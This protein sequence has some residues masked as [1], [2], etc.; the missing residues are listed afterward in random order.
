MMVGS[1]AVT[2]TAGLRE[3]KKDRTRQA[4]REAALRLFAERGF[5]GVTVAEIA[6]EAD[7]S[8]ATVFNYFPTKE[9]LV[10]GGME[11]FEA[12]LVEAVREREPGESALTAFTRFIVEPRGWLG[13]KDP[14]AAKR[15]TAMTRVITTSSELLARENEIFVRYT[16]SLAELVAAETGASARDPT[17][18]V[19]AN[20]M[21]GVHRALL[22]E[23]RKEI[24]AG[25]S[26]TQVA[27]RVRAHGKRVLELLERGLRDYA[28]KRR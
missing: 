19:A 1:R 14:E 27:R 24:L 15:L 16:Q 25:A 13:S 5:S 6:T 2:T 3:R 21:I 26:T 28:V 18:W 8:V 17:P 23:T 7:V 22:G 10:Y 11:S 4:I 9:D 12:E 20:A